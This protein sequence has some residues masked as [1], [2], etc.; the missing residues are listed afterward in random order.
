MR[1]SDWSSDV[2]SSDLRCDTEN[3]HPDHQLAPD[4]IT[5]RS[6]EHG[7]ARDREQE[8]E[9][10]EL[11]RLRAQ[12]EAM[13]QIKRVITGDARQIE[14]LRE[15]KQHQHDHRT[16]RSEERSVGNEWV[17]TCNSRRSTK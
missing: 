13:H 16:D 6:T 14:V 1:I 12:A 2:C 17:S 7:P 5:D 10:I 11:R 8:R 3:R 9:Q 4:A 15:H